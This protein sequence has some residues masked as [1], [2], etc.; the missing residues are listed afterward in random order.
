MTLLTKTTASLVSANEA[1][2]QKLEL[3][4]A[5]NEILRDFV[6]ST[7]AAAM[8]KPNA[9]LSPRQ[10]MPKSPSGSEYNNERQVKE[11]TPDRPS[12]GRNNIRSESA[13]S[14]LLSANA[15]WDI[16]QSHPLYSK[17][18]LDLNEVCEHLSKMAW[19]DGTDPKFEEHE[20]R[21][22]IQDL[23]GANS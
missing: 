8:G 1:L 15:V 5:E 6:S 4:R 7:R 16:V 20:V 21:R 12:V 2:R 18:D 23:G 3:V 11:R 22:I 17:G 10:L 19:R 9:H 14:C 13:V